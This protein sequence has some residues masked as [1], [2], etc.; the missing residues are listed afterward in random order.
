MQSAS[1]NSEFY[2][3][4]DEV[5][6]YWNTTLEQKLRRFARIQL[7]NPDTIDAIVCRI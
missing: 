6:N 7:Y 1:E 2:Q 5:L 3:Y 4:A